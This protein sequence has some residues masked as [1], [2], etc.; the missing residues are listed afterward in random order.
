MRRPPG[1]TVLNP[2]DTW[3]LNISKMSRWTLSIS[4]GSWES[5]VAQRLQSWTQE[6]PPTSSADLRAPCA[7]H[8]DQT[9]VDAFVRSNVNQLVSPLCHERLAFYSSLGRERRMLNKSTIRVLSGYLLPTKRALLSRHCLVSYPSEDCSS[10]DLFTTLWLAL[11][12]H[13]RQI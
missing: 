8:P 11:L 6:C 9:S 1:Q 7:V 4:C 13:L 12:A 5:T 10:V 2:S 3:K